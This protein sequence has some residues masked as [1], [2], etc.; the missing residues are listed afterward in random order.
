MVLYAHFVVKSCSFNLTFE[1]SKILLPAFVHQEN[2]P[3]GPILRN[4]SVLGTSEVSLVLIAVI[5]FL[6]VTP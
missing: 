3:L 4:T 6:L 1:R 5:I 2:L